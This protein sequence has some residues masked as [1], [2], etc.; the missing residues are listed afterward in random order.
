MQ[1][2][3]V[4]VVYPRELPRLLDENGA[5]PGRAKVVLENPVRALARMGDQRQLVRNGVYRRQRRV[6]VP[7]SDPEVEVRRGLE[8]HPGVPAANLTSSPANM[9]ASTTNW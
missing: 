5:H 4:Q 6:D 9:P 3:A 7:A 8:Q 2:K 1:A